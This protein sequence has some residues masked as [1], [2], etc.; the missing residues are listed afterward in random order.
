MLTSFPQTLA[1]WAGVVFTACA[2]GSL[3]FSAEQLSEAELGRWRH[4]ALSSPPIRLPGVFDQQTVVVLPDGRFISVP[5]EGNATI[6]S[7]D[8]GQTWSKPRPIRPANSP[9]VP[10]RG[11]LILTKS[12][13]LVLPFETIGGLETRWDE[14]KRDWA[15]AFHKG[16]NLWF[17]RSTDQGETWAEPQ[18]YTGGG[19]EGHYGTIV[20]SI[21][22]GSGHIVVPIQVTLQNP[23]HWGMY[24]FVSADDGKTWSRS[25]LIDLGGNGH[26]DGAIE[27]TVAELS[28]GRL[29]MLI[30]TGYGKFWEAYS[31]DHGY[32]WLEVRPSQLDSAAAPGYMK[33]LA[34][35]RLV[36]IWS[37]LAMEGAAIPPNSGPSAAYVNGVRSQRREF[38]MTYSDD[39]AKSWSSPVVITRQAKGSASYPFI[40]EPH[41]GELWIWTRYGSMPSVYLKLSEHDLVGL[42][43]A[44]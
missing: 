38:S 15:P 17:T 9:V 40:L 19:D 24:G 7:T 32:N 34:S 29:M 22:T 25:N 13:V 12:G 18:Q 11:P 26:H 21:Q 2:L 4:P 35:G 10:T 43:R 3:A 37:R 36:L 23:G 27:A 1:R 44:P 6:V 33:R 39:D 8:N 14:A 30:R 16:Q 20:S 5:P 42:K 31:D 28:N 41:P